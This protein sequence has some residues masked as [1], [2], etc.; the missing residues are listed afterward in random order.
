MLSSIFGVDLRSTMD[1]DTTI[2]GLSL[3]RETITKAIRE[4]ITTIVPI[5]VSNKIKTV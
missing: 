4:I 3:D 1:L 5:V 2:K